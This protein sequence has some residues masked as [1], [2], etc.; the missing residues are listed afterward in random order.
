LANPTQGLTYRWCIDDN[1][2][3]IVPADRRQEP[4]LYDLRADPHEKRNAARKK[5]E[6]VQTLSVVL[7]AWWPGTHSKHK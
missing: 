7:D 3:L 1:W 4:E 5:P 2:K 6:K